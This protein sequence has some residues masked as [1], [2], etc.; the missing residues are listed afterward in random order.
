ML[1]RFNPG[2]RG[3][4]HIDELLPTVDDM[5]QALEV[6]EEAAQ[7]FHL[8]ISCSI[9]I[10]P[11]LIDLSAYPHLGHGFCAAGSSRAYYTLDAVGNVRPCN[12]TPT[13]LGNAW[14]EPFADIIAPERLAEFVAAMPEFCASCARREECQGGCKA[15]AQGCYGDLCAEEP[16]L[17]QHRD[18]ARPISAAGALDPCITGRSI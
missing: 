2:G 15:A 6:A 9:P 4:A 13:V 12:H 11:C 10:Q 16:F 3:V 1:N 8:P 7:E 17:H 5:R 14:Q 18:R